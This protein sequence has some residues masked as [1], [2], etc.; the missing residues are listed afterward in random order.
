[1][2]FLTIYSTGLRLGEGLR[3]E[4]GDID[5]DHGRIHVR[6]AKGVRDRYVPLPAT[7]LEA[8]RGFWATHRHPRLLFPNPNGGPALMRAATVPMHSGGVQQAL[9]ATV[10][11]CGIHRKISPH[12]LRHSY[13][14]HLLELGVDLREI[15]T[16]LGHASPATTARY[17]RLTEVTSKQATDQIEQMLNGFKLCWEDAA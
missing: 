3:I 10:S 15:Q 6:N 9:K 8:L 7:T 4:V 11:D 1:M 13:A 12:S 5:G 17:T 16:I 2:F 14:T